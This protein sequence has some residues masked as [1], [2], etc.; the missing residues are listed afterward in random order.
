MA[1]KIGFKEFEMGP[2][3]SVGKGKG[4]GKPRKSLPAAFPGLNRAKEI[5]T[6]KEKQ[7][8]A[9]AASERDTDVDLDD[10]DSPTVRKDSRYDGLGL[11]RPATALPPFA[12]P[13]G[14]GKA[15]RASWLMRRS[16]SGAFSSSS[17]ASSVNATPTRLT[18]KGMVPDRRKHILF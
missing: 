13:S 16:S 5:K 8:T 14:D 15:G 17:D 6:T 18:P 10:A 1:H 7:A 9:A 11:G 4:K 3:E 12:R 2:G